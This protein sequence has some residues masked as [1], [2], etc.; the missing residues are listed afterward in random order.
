MNRGLSLAILYTRESITR[1]GEIAK[2][3]RAARGL[4]A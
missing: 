3:I 2:L 4:L 1:R